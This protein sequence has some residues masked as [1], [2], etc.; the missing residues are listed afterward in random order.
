M[1]ELKVIQFHNINPHKTSLKIL[2]DVIFKRRKDI[3]LRNVD[4]I[5]S[6]ILRS[7]FSFLQ[8]VK[9]ANNELFKDFY[10][11]VKMEKNE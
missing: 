6:T 10:N 9:S 7:Y 2:N 11:E 4:K 5:T 1:P 8:G 3:T